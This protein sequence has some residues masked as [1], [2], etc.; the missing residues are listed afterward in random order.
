MMKKIIEMLMVEIE[1]V[2]DLS[3]YLYKQG[4]SLR[5]LYRKNEA[6]QLWAIVEL[7]QKKT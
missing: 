3:D 5:G 4:K 1:R 7:I 2:E 6:K